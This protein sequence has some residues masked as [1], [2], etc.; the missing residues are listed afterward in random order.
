MLKI[1][2]RVLLTAFIAGFGLSVL[3]ILFLDRAI[4]EIVRPAFAGQQALWKQITYLG[5]SEWM[6]LLTLTIIAIGL[7]LNHFQ[8]KPLWS[9][10][11]RYGT[12][13]F[14]P[15]AVVGISALLLKNMI[16]RARPYVF[17]TEGPFSFSPF[18]FEN[19][20][21]GFPS[22]H[23]TMAF[24]FA[25][26]LAILFPRLAIPAFAFA[27]LAGFSRMAVNAHYLGDVIFGATFGT[28]V[29]IFVAKKLAAKFKYKV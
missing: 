9:R 26:M 13:V 24:A 14:I 8:P 28:I 2:D 21:A 6:A 23:T 5:D 22:G 15:A 18:A 11:W 3:S 20:F 1:P 10:M 25:T 29:T 27:I 4:Y 19:N 7:I 16:G 17:D 12:F